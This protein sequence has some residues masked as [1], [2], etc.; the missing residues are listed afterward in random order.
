MPKGR[1]KGSEN[2]A[3]QAQAFVKRIETMLNKKS[4]QKSPFALE[5]EACRFIES[6]DTKVAFGVWSKLVE[7]KFGKPVQPNEHSGKDGEPIA[8][9][10]I[11]N[12]QI[13]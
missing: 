4:G 1:P 9:Q 2:R 8:V 13:P 12:V 5:R 7:Y 3:P 11:T 6:D 10:I